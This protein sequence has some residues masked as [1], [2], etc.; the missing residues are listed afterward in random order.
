MHCTQLIYTLVNIPSY[1]TYHPPPPQTTRSNHHLNPS[2]NPTHLPDI[3]HHTEP[4][5]PPDRHVIMPHISNICD[6][7]ERAAAPPGAATAGAAARLAG[8]AGGDCQKF[9]AKFGAF[10]GVGAV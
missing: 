3:L 5:L 9:G 8:A 1:T 6:A 2:P 10:G 7:S 4:A